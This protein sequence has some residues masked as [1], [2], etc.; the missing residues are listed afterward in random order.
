MRS[1]VLDT[2]NR[3]HTWMSA[4]QVTKATGMTY[5]QTIDALN[6]LLNEERVAR[7]GRTFTAQWGGLHMIK[8]DPA[9]AA[10][11]LLEGFFHATASRK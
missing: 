11:H 6:A 2:V 1:R 4:A 3:S 5:K 8:P 9:V 7:K 10:S